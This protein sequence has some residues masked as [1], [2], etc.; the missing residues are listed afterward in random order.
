MTAKL[1]PLPGESGARYVTVDC[2]ECGISLNSGH[3]YSAHFPG[4]KFAEALMD[5]H[6]EEHHRPLDCLLDGDTVTE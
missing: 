3:H 4:R 5:A 2:D 6:N 1:I